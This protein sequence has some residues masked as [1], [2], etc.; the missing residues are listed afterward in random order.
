M[1]KLMTAGERGMVNIKRLDYYEAMQTVGI[2]ML[3]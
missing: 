1:S 2:R 3:G